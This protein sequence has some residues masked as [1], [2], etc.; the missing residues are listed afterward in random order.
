MGLVRGR[1]HTPGHT[2][3]CRFTSQ[4]RG[5]NCHTTPRLFA[6]DTLFAGSIAAPA[7][8]GSM[9]QITDSLRGKLMLLPDE[10]IVHPGHGP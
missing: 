6:G 5:S 10:T 2:P 9:D 4:G 8:G 3:K 7:V 1:D